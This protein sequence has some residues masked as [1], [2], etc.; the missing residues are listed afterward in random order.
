MK[1]G[2][3]KISK[4]S[5]TKS[6]LHQTTEQF[7]H[8]KMSTVDFSLGDTLVTVSVDNNTLLSSIIETLRVRLSSS[9]LL[10]DKM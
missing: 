2:I 5:Y 7:I 8:I 10:L 9:L 4:S 6:W 1:N 3:T